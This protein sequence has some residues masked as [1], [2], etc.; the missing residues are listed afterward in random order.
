MK[1]CQ[2]N[3]KAVDL[4]ELNKILRNG[5]FNEKTRKRRSGTVNFVTGYTIDT[6]DDKQA[7][8]RDINP[9]NSNERNTCSDEIG[10]KLSQLNIQDFITTLHNLTTVVTH[11]K[12][13]LYELEISIQ[14]NNLSNASTMQILNDRMTALAKVHI[15]HNQQSTDKMQDIEEEIQNV[16]KIK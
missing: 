11:L 10:D 16:N 5:D 13:K 1:E 4:N 9:T 2:I 14:A 12:D 15:Q 6:S 8:L 7:K 3:G